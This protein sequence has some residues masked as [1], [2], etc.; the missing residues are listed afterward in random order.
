MSPSLRH[1]SALGAALVLSFG[2][3]TSEVAFAAILTTSGI[4]GVISSGTGAPAADGTYA[5]TFAI[6]PQQ[7]GGTAVWTETLT[8]VVK[9]GQFSK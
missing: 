1:L 4:E 3:W 5:T 8:L 6:Y 7:T 2:C 9:N